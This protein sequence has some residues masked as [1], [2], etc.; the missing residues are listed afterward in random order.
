MQS[1][2]RNPAGPTLPGMATSHDDDQAHDPKGYSWLE[3]VMTAALVG[4][5]VVLVGLMIDAVVSRYVILAPESSPAP[6]P[7]VAEAADPAPEPAGPPQTGQGPP[8]LHAVEAPPL[9][10]PA[11]L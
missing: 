8:N 9:T 4:A 7:L 5:G 1:T 10:D 6:A 11:E 2:A 3:F